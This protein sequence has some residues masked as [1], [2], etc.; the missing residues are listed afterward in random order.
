MSLTQQHDAPDYRL[1]CRRCGQ[2]FIE[3]MQLAFHDCSGVPAGK[4]RG[5]TRPPRRK[6][7]KN[8]RDSSR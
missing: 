7:T 4:S 3:M 5:R 6:G 8:R 2:Q 1:R